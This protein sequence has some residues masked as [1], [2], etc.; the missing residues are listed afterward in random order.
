MNGHLDGFAGSGDPVSLADLL[1]DASV[2]L[3]ICRRDWP[4]PIEP[5]QEWVYRRR[6]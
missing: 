1:P 4:E 5:L 6:E 2:S 3:E